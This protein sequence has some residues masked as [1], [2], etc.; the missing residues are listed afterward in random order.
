MLRV[1]VALGLVLA[2]PPPEQL[3]RDQARL[4]GWAEPLAVAL[5]AL[6]PDPID[7]LDEWAPWDDQFREPPAWGCP[8]GCTVYPQLVV[9]RPYVV[10]EPMLTRKVDAAAQKALLNATRIAADPV[11]AR[12]QAAQQ[13]LE[14]E[15]ETLKRSVRRLTLTIRVNA[16]SAVPQGVEAPAGDAGS[17]AGRRVARFT[18]SDETYAPTSAGVRLAVLVGDPRFQNA[19]A[20]DVTGMTT[21]AMTALVSVAVQSRAET[22]TADEALARQLLERVDF[23]SLVKILRP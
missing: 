7:G 22:I 17:V 1:A 20:R 19:P 6:L 9:Q 18:F 12:L 8:L 13:S 5:T 16:G 15:E 21:E 10:A 23:A 4:D 3:A 2:V 11:N 14:D